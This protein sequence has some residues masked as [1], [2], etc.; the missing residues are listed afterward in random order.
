MEKLS[1]IFQDS[2]CV[3]VFAYADGKD[4]DGNFKMI[5]KLEHKGHQSYGQKFT[6]IF[7][8]SFSVVEVPGDVKAEVSE[9]RLTIQRDNQLNDTGMTEIWIK[10]KAEEQ[11]EVLEITDVLCCKEG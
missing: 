3:T 4:G 10:L 7:D 8:N 11:P 1:A 9:N 5:F 2:T 6:A